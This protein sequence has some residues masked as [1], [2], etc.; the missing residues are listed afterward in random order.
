M[1][2]RRHAPSPGSTRPSG[3]CR[4]APC[5]SSTWPPRRH[6]AA[7]RPTS[8]PSGRARRSAFTFA[9]PAISCATTAGLP[10]R[11]ATIT[12]V[13]PARSAAFGLAPAASSRRTIAS[14]PFWLAVQS[15]VAPRSFA[16]FTL[17]PGA[18]QQVARSRHRPDSSPSAG[19]V[20]PSAS[21]A[22]TL[23]PCWSSAR[24]AVAVAG[25]GRV[26]QRRTPSAP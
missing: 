9:P 4:S 21:A 26:D 17:A 5:A 24:S 12:G 19:P 18:N 8:A 2:V 1:S 20:V 22:L 25:S 7:T 3:A 15:G 13:S 10:E 23:A 14:L 6:A 16:A 11:A